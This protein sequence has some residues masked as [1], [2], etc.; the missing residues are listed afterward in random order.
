MIV[1]L[2]NYASPLSF[3]HPRRMFQLQAASSAPSAQSS[4]I[5]SASSSV[6]PSSQTIPAARRF[7]SL[8]HSSSSAF[9]VV[10][11]GHTKERR[12]L[13]LTH[14]SSSAFN[15]VPTGHTKERR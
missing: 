1:Y 4:Q 14:S 6:P 10:P 8:T 11:T 2:K 12:F 7:L 3:S 5:N 15:V 13:S 9:N